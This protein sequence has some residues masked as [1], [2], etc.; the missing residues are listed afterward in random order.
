MSANQ[1][2]AINAKEA[3]SI[4]HP[5]HREI[6]ACLNALHDYTQG[7]A[8]SEYEVVKYEQARLTQ[9]Q[10]NINVGDLGL[11]ANGGAPAGPKSAESDTDK[12]DWE[13][14][15]DTLT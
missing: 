15:E 6:S 10:A 13:V 8:P 12:I 2:G 11:A 5:L 14:D 4:L 7:R 3:E 9:Q 1:D